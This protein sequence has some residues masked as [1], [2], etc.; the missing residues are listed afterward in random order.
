[1]RSAQQASYW[2]LAVRLYAPR[3]DQRHREREGVLS[4]AKSLVRPLLLNQSRRISAT[5]RL[6]RRCVLSF[7]LTPPRTCPL[8]PPRS[9]HPSPV[10]ALYCFI[11]GTRPCS[12]GRKSLRMES[13]GFGKQNRWD[14]ASRDLG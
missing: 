13:G 4:L 10:S 14:R 12:R 1:V 3:L 7:L 2:Y 9:S 6:L 5:S 11:L 8:T